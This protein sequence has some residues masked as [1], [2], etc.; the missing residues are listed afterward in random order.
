MM[1]WGLGTELFKI[2]LLRS[3]VGG[4][5][6]LSIYWLISGMAG[7]GGT[8]LFKTYLDKSGSLQGGQGGQIGR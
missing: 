7:Q 1:G 3:G 5:S 8:E 4:H 2:Y 6:D